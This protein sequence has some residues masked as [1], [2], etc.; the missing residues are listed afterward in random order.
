[1]TATHVGL[2]DK[3]KNQNNYTKALII[4]P[5]ISGADFPSFSSYATLKNTI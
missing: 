1:M 5:L 4:F 2:E 3:K